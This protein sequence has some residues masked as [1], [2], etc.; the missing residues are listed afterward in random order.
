MTNQKRVTKTVLVSLNNWQELNQV[1][2][3][4]NLEDLDTA[5]SFIIKKAKQ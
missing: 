1:K 4:N 3:D 5:L 2:I